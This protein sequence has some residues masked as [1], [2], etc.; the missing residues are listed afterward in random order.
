MVCVCVCVSVRVLSHMLDQRL[1]DLVA[2]GHMRHHVFHVVLRRSH[3]RGAEHQRQVARLHLHTCGRGR[4]Q[5]VGAKPVPVRMSSPPPGGK[6]LATHL[7]L[8]G[9]VGH[10]LQVADQELESVVVVIGKVA[11]LN[12]RRGATAVRKPVGPDRPLP[13]TH[14]PR[15]RV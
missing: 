5:G 3:Q 14:T 6:R 13:R 9:V 1:H 7:V 12:D 8:V 11:D 4:E 10:R 15:A 2:V